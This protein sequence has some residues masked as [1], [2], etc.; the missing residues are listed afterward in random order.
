MDIPAATQPLL[1][2]W[3][4]QMGDALMDL[5][6]CYIVLPS[7]EAVMPIS[8]VAAVLSSSYPS[9]RISEP[10][11]VGWRRKLKLHTT[12]PFLPNVLLR[13]EF[14]RKVQVCS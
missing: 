13:A 6:F 1:P 3:G 2:A 14:Y 8:K 9:S 10:R 7:A 5:S 11:K 12:L 4:H